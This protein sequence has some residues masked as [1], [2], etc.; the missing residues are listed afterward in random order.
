MTTTTFETTHVMHLPISRQAF[1]F[2]QE[3]DRGNT[4]LLDA[5]DCQQPGVLAVYRQAGH[6]HEGVQIASCDEEVYAILEQMQ[7]TWCPWPD[8]GFTLVVLE[9]AQMGVLADRLVVQSLLE[10]GSR[11]DN[12]QST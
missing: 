12:E 1:G 4:V 3:G 8:R 7:L 9:H 6:V 11:N 2:P 5:R 10:Q